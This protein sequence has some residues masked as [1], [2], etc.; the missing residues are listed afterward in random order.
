LDKLATE[1]LT[2]Y[3]TDLHGTVEITT[4]GVEYSVRTEELGPSETPSEPEPEPDPEQAIPGF[5]PYHI[6]AGII[7]ALTILQM[8]SERNQHSG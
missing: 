6:A 1:G 5:N 4:D 7:L 3:R 2:V 8:M